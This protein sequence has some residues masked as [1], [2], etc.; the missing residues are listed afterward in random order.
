MRSI[1]VCAL[2]LAGAVHALGDWRDVRSFSTESDP[3]HVDREQVDLFWGQS[4]TVHWEHTAMRGNRPFQLDDS[5]SYMW[6]V[7][8]G[9]NAY[10]AAE[11]TVE[12]A[13]NGRVSWRLTPV[14]SNLA[15]GTYEGRVIAIEG[16]N[17]NRG[18]LVRA[19]VVVHYSPK[20]DNFEIVG[21][22]LP[23]P[24]Q[25]VTD[26]TIDGDGT[27][28]DPLSVANP[29]TGF[30]TLAN[31]YEGDTPWLD[32]GFIT[33]VDWDE[34]TGPEIVLRRLSDNMLEVSGA[35]T[36]NANGIYVH[37]DSW[38]NQTSGWLIYKASMP[39]VVTEWIIGD[40]TEDP[41]YL[42]TFPYLQAPDHPADVAEWTV[43]PEGDAPTPSVERVVLAE[44]TY[45]AEGLEYD[46]LLNAPALFAPT[47]L[48]T[49]YEADWA[50]LKNFVSAEDVGL[51]AGDSS[52][53]VAA[54]NTV[55]LNNFMSLSWPNNYPL[56]LNG[57]Y[58]FNDALIVGRQ[59]VRIFG[60]GARFIQLNTSEHG[61]ELTSTSNGFNLRGLFIEGQ[62]P[63]THDA[64]GIYGRKYEDEVAVYI[65]SNVIL[66]DVDIRQF[67]TGI[68]LAQVANFLSIN[69]TIRNVRWGFDFDTLQTGTMLNNRVT[70]GD[71]HAD[72]A[73][74][75]ST[76]I[77][78]ANHVI[79]GEFGWGFERFFRATDGR[80]H[81][82][83]INVEGFASKQTA[84]EFTDPSTEKR[85]SIT[86]SRMGF[87]RTAEQSIVAAA[88][89][90]NTGVVSLNWAGNSFP[91]GRILE[92]VGPRTGFNRILAPGVRVFWTDTL[93]GTPYYDAYVHAATHQ[94]F[95]IASLPSG[96]AQP[97]A[98]ATLHSPTSQLTDLWATNPLVFYRSNKSDSNKWGSV[99]NDMLHQVL[100]YSN[101][102]AGGTNET[103]F[104]SNT[105]PQNFLRSNGES[106]EIQAFGTTAA[107]DNNKRIRFK[108][109]G[110]TLFDFGDIPMNDVAW[111]LRIYVQRG[112]WGGGAAHMKILG[113]LKYGNE[114]I[115]RA[116]E[117][118][119]DSAA[120]TVAITGEGV[121]ANDIVCLATKATWTRA[122]QGF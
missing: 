62:G 41:A 23:Q 51:V 118:S 85:L 16:E 70:T 18:E 101:R 98:K 34:I 66:Q 2:L 112:P 105:I 11:G 56:V 36:A 69:T 22:I 84:F 48:I 53:G 14:E 100:F 1:V 13:A 71:D 3:R 44:T 52:S 93:G 103:T 35:G 17:I 57:T 75:V 46:D 109:A 19:K 73:I 63:A 95:A 5:L 92:L 50:N 27:A 107:N 42:A 83:A 87:A 91:G 110:S 97:G 38:E 108:W 68:S 12:S 54:A 99:S 113:E 122:P 88:I 72:S 7:M 55:A 28:G 4:E 20:G 104:V 32:Q 77:G 39:D 10:V 31:D 24:I 116:A 9:T 81:F 117:G 6:Y 74:F 78:F 89:T 115:V 111:S 80:W 15:P 47:D 76:G 40:E 59:Y 45:A 30:D 102:V 33:G 43:G 90:N 21:P 119:G 61:F 96:N 121:D 49:D 26:S 106:V 120:I 94:V 114:T 60:Y 67:R 82:D 8:D 86:N 37:G 29:F 25:I 79:G 65:T 58:Y 64:A